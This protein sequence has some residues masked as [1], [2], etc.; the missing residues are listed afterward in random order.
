MSN[1]VNH[2][3]EE[4]T[5]AGL[6]DKDSDYDGML[7]PAILKM[8]EVFAAE[9]HSGMS[10]SI[11]LSAFDRVARFKTLAP[12]TNHPSE[13][14]DVKE[15]DPSGPGIWQNKRDSSYFSNDGGKTGYSVDDKKRKIVVFKPAPM[16]I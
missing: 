15:F 14:M 6:F 9:G 3:K 5:R 2:A 12:L 4:L 11:C 10:A 7:G 16:A 8:V 13:W 1:L